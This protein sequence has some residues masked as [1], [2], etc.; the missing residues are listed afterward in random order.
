MNSGNTPHV[1]FAVLLITIFMFGSSLCPENKAQ[2]QARSNEFCSDYNNYKNDK[3]SFSEVRELTLP[4]ANLL[5]VNGERNGGIRVKGDNRTNILVRA[6]VRAQASSEEAAQSL[7]RSVR[8]E[9][10]PVVRATDVSAENS[11]TSVSYEILVPRQTDLK[12]TANNG[13]IGISGV[14]GS[15]EFETANGGI[16][17]SD[18]AGN[19]RGKTRN[20]GVHVTLSGNSWR[21]AGLDVETTN[22]GV[23]L[24]LPETYQAR[25]ETGTV[26]GGFKSEIPALQVERKERER[27]VRLNTDFNGGGAPV[28]LITTN[29]GVKI[30]S[31]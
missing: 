3:V 10:S 17:L 20:G 23:H 11:W 18:V 27:A 7:A 15:I 8:V 25:L 24:N 28:R 22:G 21:G 6:C 1:R 30:N 26:N 2:N 19:V 5:E 9:T 13:G 12:L 14:D 29:G 31:H 16:H 4:V